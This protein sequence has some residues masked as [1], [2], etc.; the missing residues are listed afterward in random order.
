MRRLQ[1]IATVLMATGPLYAAGA[2]RRVDGLETARWRVEKW[3]NPARLRVIREGVRGRVLEA[4]WLPGRQ[5]KA[6]FTLPRRWN[7]ME[8]PLLVLDVRNPGRTFTRL[9][10]G[11]RTGKKFVYFESSLRRPPPGGPYLRAYYDFSQANFKCRKYHWIQGVPITNLQAARNL[12]LLIYPYHVHRSTG[13]LLF[14]NVRLARGAFEYVRDAADL[15]GGDAF[16]RTGAAVKADF[17]ND[18]VLDDLAPGQPPL[19][20]LSRPDGAAVDAAARSGLPRALPPG[21]ACGDVDG[22]GCVDVVAA[23][24]GRWPLQIFRGDGKGRFQDATSD[25]AFPSGESFPPVERV[26]LE[27]VE[28]DGDL[29]AGVLFDDGSIGLL[30]QV[31]PH[32]FRGRACIAV[33]AASKHAGDAALVLCDAAGRRRSAAILRASLSGRTAA[34]VLFFARP[35]VYRLLAKNADGST[36]EC[37]F[38]LERRGQRIT[39][40]R[41]R[42]RALWPKAPVTIDGKMSPGEWSRARTLRKTLSYID[43]KTRRNETHEMVVHYLADAAAVYFC[44]QIA[45]DDFGGPQQPD[46]LEVH[47]DNDND[48]EIE[49]GEDFKSFWSQI[50]NDYHLPY[51]RDPWLDGLGRC[52]HS[53]PK[54]VGD[55][56][57]ELMIPRFSSDP[58]DVRIPDGKP[59]GVKFIFRESQRVGYTWRIATRWGSD[60]LPDGLPRQG[61]TYAKMVVQRADPKTGLADMIIQLPHLA[62]YVRGRVTGPNGE[63]LAHARVALFSIHSWSP[64]SQ[65][66]AGADGAYRL[67]LPQ[68]LLQGDERLMLIASAPGLADQARPLADPKAEYDF[69]LQPG[70]VLKGR[71]VGR[72]GK[73]IASAAVYVFAD[74]KKRAPHAYARSYVTK[75]DGRFRFD[76]APDGEFVV[77]V[78]HGTLGSAEKRGVRSGQNV[79]IRLLGSARVAGRVVDA[80][81]GKP[82]SVVMV[83]YRLQYSSR[84]STVRQ[85]TTDGRFNITLPGNVQDSELTFKS[86]G[87]EPLTWKRRISGGETLAGLSVALKPLAAA[88]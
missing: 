19:L 25:W 50:Y 48:G 39:L 66:V 46:M 41:G 29:D 63:P 88:R 78:S 37:R 23:G 51:F 86:D 74:Q 62:S 56:I 54:G 32:G 42:L 26:I 30:R 70:R 52:S 11:L 10:A 60:G 43:I 24:E 2:E 4:T 79:T 57:F 21:L 73:P 59:V 27:D 5:D 36:A 68:N 3:A 1:A 44:I 55:Y 77:W 16:W 64:A 34:Q 61:A 71:V 9:A 83:S 67:F 84:L 31:S 33:S 6:V 81:T 58:D 7:A 45:G 53:N 69:R 65:T 15:V 22:D 14:D 38:V 17:N 76:N 28:P 8:R 80:R 72:D 20:L 82:L 49:D 35:G 40:D 47:F 18:G 85:F 75:A 13:K 12:T 87:Y